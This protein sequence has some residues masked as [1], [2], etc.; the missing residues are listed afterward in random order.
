MIFFSSYWV[1]GPQAGLAR[2][3]CNV[4]AGLL[5]T[6]VS[7]H[8]QLGSDVCLQHSSYSEQFF[9]KSITDGSIYDGV[10]S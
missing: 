1:P 9:P 2:D 10:Y 8:W 7:E 5:W 3:K 6:L 4:L